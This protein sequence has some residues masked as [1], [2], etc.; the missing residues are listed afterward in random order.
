IAYNEELEAYKEANKR[1]VA[2]RCFKCGYVVYNYDIYFQFHT[3]YPEG[4]VYCP[5]C[6][7][8]LSRNLF[9]YAEES[10]QETGA[11]HHD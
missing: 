2:A 10:P 9:N 4:F 1:K 11:V 8:P 5:Y 7:Q 3:R 6:R